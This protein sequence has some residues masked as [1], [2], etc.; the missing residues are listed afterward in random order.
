MFRQ[1]TP[2]LMGIT[3]VA[4]LLFTA[5]GGDN[6]R[7]DP[8]D[9]QAESNRNLLVGNWLREQTAYHYLGK[10]DRVELPADS[11]WFAFEMNGVSIFTQRIQGAYHQ[12]LY[13]WTVSD[14]ELILTS[15]IQLNTGKFEYTLSDSV[16][17][18]IRNLETMT[19]DSLT[20][21]TYTYRRVE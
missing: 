13:S 5:C 2:L 8:S 19:Q 12:Q 6:R 9:L 1:T 15:D 21:W 18:Y 10:D 7:N 4:A 17:T 16:L 20:G 3:F 11:M 14:S